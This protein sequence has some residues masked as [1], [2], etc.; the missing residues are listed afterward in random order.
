[1]A[2]IKTGAIVVTRGAAVPG[3]ERRMHSTLNEA[4][5]YTNRVAEQGRIDETLFFV[6]KTGPNR[7]TLMLRGD[8]RRWRPCSQTRSSR[9]SCRTGCWSS[10]TSTSPCG[11]GATQCRS[12]KASASTRTSFAATAC[13]KPGAE[14]RR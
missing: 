7:D 11:L 4:M 14:A 3:R 6:A 10:R 1:M 8:W 5:A 2:S 12:Q 9:N 13:C